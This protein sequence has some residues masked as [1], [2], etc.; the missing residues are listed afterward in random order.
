MQLGGCDGAEVHAG[1][2]VSSQLEA[3]A[4]SAVAVHPPAHV[5]VS[6]AAHTFSTATS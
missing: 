4:T 2:Q 1:T 5:V 3:H 6:R